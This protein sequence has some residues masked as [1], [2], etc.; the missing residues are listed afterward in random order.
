M[1]CLSL[2]SSTE[3]IVIMKNKMTTKKIAA[4]SAVQTQG[5]D[6]HI[7]FTKTSFHHEAAENGC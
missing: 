4:D 7:S 1:L 2:G 3:V 5:L 6:L